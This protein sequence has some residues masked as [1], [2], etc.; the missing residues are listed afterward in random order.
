MRI[1]I[2]CPQGHV[3]AFAVPLEISAEESMVTPEE[4]PIGCDAILAGGTAE[5]GAELL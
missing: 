1:E 3:T 4:A 5:S 2:A